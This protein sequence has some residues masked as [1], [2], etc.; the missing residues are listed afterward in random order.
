M[1]RR[2]FMEDEIIGIVPNMKKSK[3][4]GLSYDAFTLV[5]T[6]DTIYLPR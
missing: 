1:S 3:M 6:P 4:L 5:A 2:Y